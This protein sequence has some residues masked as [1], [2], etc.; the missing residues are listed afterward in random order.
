MSRTFGAQASISLH[1]H[2]SAPPLRL[3]RLK[4]GPTFHASPFRTQ[5][6]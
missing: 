4:T 2:G 3:D 5:P 6:L 1:R